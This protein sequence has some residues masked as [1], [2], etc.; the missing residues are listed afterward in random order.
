[1]GTTIDE[2]SIVGATSSLFKSTE[3]WSV[4]GG[5]PAKFLKK[6]VVNKFNK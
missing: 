1:M 2:G 4:Y 6:R 3:A 5:N